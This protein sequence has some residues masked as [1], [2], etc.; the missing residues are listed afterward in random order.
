MFVIYV[1]LAILVGCGFA[2][3]AA[4]TSKISVVLIS[5]VNAVFVS[6][7]IGVL[8]L[9]CYKILTGNLLI[10]G[11]RGVSPWL[12]I[13]GGV[14]GVFSLTILIF[15]TPKIGISLSIGIMVASQLIVA[16]L[17]DH[18]GVLGLEVRPINLYKIIGVFFLLLGTSLCLY[19]R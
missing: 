15:I 7:S 19:F 3:Q 10:A 17:L 18:F 1:I 11:V 5:P 8:V 13:C 6:L 16:L 14:L 2:T 9:L 4:I 12:Y